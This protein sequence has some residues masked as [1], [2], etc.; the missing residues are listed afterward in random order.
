[1]KLKGDGER[2]PTPLL[3]A[4]DSS[5]DR[6]DGRTGPRIQGSGGLVHR[7][8]GAFGRRMGSVERT[9]R[10]RPRDQQTKTKRRT[11][12]ALASLVARFG[13]PW[14]LEGGD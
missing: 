9:K 4:C 7:R 2:S 14:P 5:S 12:L 3:V 13:F 8:R 1:M 11:G 10:N 6:K